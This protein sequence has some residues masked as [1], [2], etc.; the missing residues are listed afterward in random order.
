MQV[1]TE[2][3]DFVVVGGGTAGSVIAARLS[4]NGN[5]RVLLLEAGSAESSHTM[6][7]PPAW[8]ALLETAANWGD[9]TVPQS[10]TGTSV[11]LARGR[12]LGGGSSIN[13]M[14]FARGHR[15]SYDAWAADGADGWGFDD[16]L[17]YFKRSENAPA[18]DPALRGVGGPLTVAPARPPHPVVAA[19]LRAA[20]EIGYRRASD[21]SGGLEEGFGWTDLNIVDGR[22]QSAA[23][24]YLAPALHRPNLTVVT[25]ALVHRLQVRNGRCVGVEYSTGN[26][27]GAAGNGAGAG[28]GTVSVGC[29]GEVV[30]T[31]GTIGSAQLLM[32]SGIGPQAHLREAG[33]EVVLDLPGVGAN[34]HDHSIAYVVYR[35]ARPVPAGASNHGE[36][37]GLVRSRLGV[38]QPDLQVL[39]VDAPGHMPS[40]DVPEQGQGYTIGVSPMRPRSRGTV[41]LASAEPSALPVVDPNY[42]GDERDLTTMVAGLR[43]ARQIGQARAVADWR[44]GEVQPG[45]D[46]DSD[47]GL[48]AYVRRTAASYLHPV[49]TCRIGDDALAVVDADLRVRGV[50][51]LRVADASVLPSIP[52]ANIIATVYAVAERAADML[53]S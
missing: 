27:S 21:V 26:G 47:A 10:A 42:F 41:R 39:L 18:R 46:V 9:I 49:G 53:R 4:E 33:V 19:L 15:S 50:G 7:A 30:L 43:L 38:P 14:T 52:S 29:S 20:T 5:A 25:G 36:A 51:G 1:I 11:S 37:I 44:G 13:A 17:P 3:Y 23:D 6:A 45:R 48:R 35:S 31:A 40:A 16:L 24:A 12:V 22:R 32:L 8:P 34:L 2:S 28:S